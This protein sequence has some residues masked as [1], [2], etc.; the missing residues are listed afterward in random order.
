MYIINQAWLNRGAEG[1]PPNNSES[2]N[3][4]RQTLGKNPLGLVFIINCHDESVMMNLSSKEG[5]LV[6]KIFR[7]MSMTSYPLERSV[8]QC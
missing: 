1:P 4:F 7:G 2:K 5:K 3:I 6:L 8:T